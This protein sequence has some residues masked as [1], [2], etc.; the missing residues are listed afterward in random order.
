M[1]TFEITITKNGKPIGEQCRDARLNVH[2]PVRVIAEEITEPGKLVSST[3]RNIS[4][5]EKATG[6]YK[7]LKGN[8]DLTFATKY[9]KAMGYT[10]ILM[11]VHI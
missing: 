6:P 2:T 11:T 4:H 3:I 8:L 5:F 9:L 10:R 7:S 1:K